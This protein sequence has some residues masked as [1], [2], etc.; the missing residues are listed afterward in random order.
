MIK[1]NIKNMVKKL[2]EYRTLFIVGLV[3]SCIIYFSLISNQ[4]VNSNDGLWEYSYYKAGK[5]SLS[6]GRWF[7][8]YIDRLRFGIST[9]PITSLISLSLFSSG[10][11]FI[12]DMF[13]LGKSKLSYLA[14]MLFLS[15]TV[16]CFSLSYRFMS[17]TFG[18]A[19]LLSVLAVWV[20]IKWNGKILTIGVSGLLMALSM[21]LYQAY[22]GC[23][24]ILLLGYFLYTLPNKTISLKNIVYYIGSALC[25]A[26]TGGILYIVI[27]NLHLKAFNVTMSS[28]NGADSY[29]VGSMIAN[30]GGSLQNIH[31]TFSRYF[32]KNY[33]NINVLQDLYIFYIVF[34]LIAVFLVIGFIK[35]IKISTPRAALYLLFVI[36]IPIASNAVLLIA[37]QA[38]TALLM[39]APM[40]LCFPIFICLIQKQEGSK[41]RVLQ[42][43]T[44]CVMVLMLYGN[45]YQVQID[46]QAMLEGK[47]ATTTMAN[48]IIDNLSDNGYLDDEVQYCIL[49]IPAGNDLFAT[50][51]IYDK[52]N[53]DARFGS[54]YQDITCTRR[55]W[56][57]VFWYLCGI[58]INICDAVGYQIVLSDETTQDM[59]SY[60]NEGY[61]KQMGEIVVIKVSE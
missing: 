19:F 55:S 40:A 3:F 60:P 9:E 14:S 34:A 8:I 7:W 12:A 6:L 17:P 11:I 35:T 33:F 42:W 26:V 58:D 43:I 56:Q 28:Y 23:T 21:G 48:D 1:E 51:A 20:L 38:W 44:I 15:S 61:I 29:S 50:S 53:S 45:I 52:A 54:W 57:G 30:L 37:A 49:G 32:F 10:F 36:L 27:L 24:C 5:W 16:I 59:P 25:A 31:L 22:I 2:Y 41:K 46:Q 47:I 4:L 18:L 39:T 13:E